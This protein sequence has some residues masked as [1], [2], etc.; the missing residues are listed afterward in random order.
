MAPYGG[1]E[2]HVCT[3]AKALSSR[4]NCVLLIS[5]SNSLSEN[6]RSQLICSG[7]RFREMGVE[8]G[9]ATTPRKALWMLVN[10][11]LLR[12]EC[13]NCVYTNGQSGLARMAW[14]AGRKATRH[15]HHHHTAADLAEQGSWCISFQS[16]LTRAESLVACS[17]SSQKYLSEATSRNDVSFIPYLTPVLCDKA[18]VKA[19]VPQR[20][21][22]MRVGFFGR[23]VSTKGIETICRISQREE[24]RSIVWE[25]YGVGERYSTSYFD[26]FESVHYHGEYGTSEQYRQI[27]LQLDAVILLSLHNEGMPLSLIEAMA[28]GLPWAAMDRGG[29]RELAFSRINCEVIDS[30]AS[31]DHI[32]GAVTRMISRIRYGETSRWVQRS[33]YETYLSPTEVAKLWLCNFE[34]LSLL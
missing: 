26:K 15:I 25:V 3:L 6:A 32:I 19:L 13:W 33:E 20:Y 10:A 34:S 21:G 1:M 17:R 8:R 7:V 2:L 28:A 29:V 22:S 12:R 14:L 24:M 16:V 23:L 30:N 27:L 11:L 5:T 4:G 31:D 18:D 9:R